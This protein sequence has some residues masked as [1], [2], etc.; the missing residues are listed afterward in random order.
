MGKNIQALFL[1]QLKIHLHRYGQP[2]LW[3]VTV[4]FITAYFDNSEALKMAIQV[5]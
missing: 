3:R 2:D 4:S 5:L 1:P